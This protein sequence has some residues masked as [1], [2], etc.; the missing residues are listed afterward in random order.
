MVNYKL[1]QPIFIP[2]YLISHCERAEQER[3]SAFSLVLLAATLALVSAH[4]VKGKTPPVTIM[5]SGSSMAKTTL[6]YFIGSD[7]SE[8]VL[9]KATDELMGGDVYL[10]RWES[11]DPIKQCIPHSSSPLQDRRLRERLHRRKGFH[12]L[13]Y[14]KLSNAGEQT[15]RILPHESGHQEITWTWKACH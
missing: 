14:V 11:E 6:A 15:P 13:L 3:M 1:K 9:Q 2:N 8:V 4:V 12:Y 7:Y 5:P 10:Y